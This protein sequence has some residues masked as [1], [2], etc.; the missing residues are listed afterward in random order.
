M[1]SSRPQT[2]LLAA[3]LFVAS[4]VV[5]WPALQA[6]F[7]GD[8]AM[9]LQRLRDVRRL[10]DAARFLGQEFFGYY[11]PLGFLSHSVDWLIAGGDS[12]QFHLTN[13]AL[14]AING[15]LVF[16]IA[17]I[18]GKRSGDHTSATKAAVVAGL[19]FAFD[20]SNHEAVAWVSARFDLLATGFSL[21]AIAWM[22][23]GA[24]GHCLGAPCLFFPALL[25]KES[26]VALPLAAAAWSVFGLRETARDTLK[27]V[28]PWLVVLAVYAL[29]RQTAGG[30]AATGGAERLPKLLMF[31]LALVGLIVCA[32]RRWIRLRDRIRVHASARSLIRLSVVAVAVTLAALLV[33]DRVV[34]LVREKIAVAGFAILYLLPPVADVPT[35]RGDLLAPEAVYGMVGLAGLPVLLLVGWTMRRWLLATDLAWFLAVWLAATLLPIS[36][37][38]E[39]R[40]YLYLPSAV[41]AVAGGMLVRRVTGPRWRVALAIVA[42]LLAASTVRILQK[43]D[44][45]R[46][47]GR[48]VAE[49]ARLGD[50]ALPPSCDG[51]HLVFLTSPVGMRG[52]YSHFY[53]ETFAQPRG[54]IP[55]RFD[56]LARVVRLETRVQVEWMDPERIELTIPDYRGNLVF[57]EDLQRFDRQLTGGSLR[58]RTPLGEVEA[59]RDGTVARVTLWLTPNLLPLPAFFYYSDG[60]VHRLAPAPGLMS[61][62]LRPG[63]AEKL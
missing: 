58:L 33:S 21:A 50:A 54:C 5:Y 9:I 12:R 17:L 18:L 19:L 15:L 47:A 8:D 23:S 57:S 53:Y 60:R 38:T 62:P 36:A 44:D 61:G 35:G 29:L 31:G 34:S 2:V 41:V 26:A 32:D 7:V 28:I 39:G 59:R 25:S 55:E 63:T 42:I 27:R 48:M 1:R 20:A 56:V 43:L 13:I 49:G 6:G 14:H 11:R 45:W 30:V 3:A 46:W 37:L 51:G 52:V 40:R 22:V 24:R 4:C 10:G 16:F